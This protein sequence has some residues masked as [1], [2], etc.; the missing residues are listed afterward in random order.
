MKLKDN[1]LLNTNITVQA[2]AYLWSEIPTIHQYKFSLKGLSV[3][4]MF[5]T[6]RFWNCYVIQTWN[7]VQPMLWICHVI[8]LTSFYTVLK[9][10][11]YS[12][13]WE[14][15]NL[16]AEFT[17]C[18]NFRNVSL[19][20]AQGWVHIL[21]LLEKFCTFSDQLRSP[22]DKPNLWWWEPLFSS[23]SIKSRSVLFSMI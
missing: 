3:A 11:V 8:S 15:M 23:E 20:N 19:I 7:H 4:A 9:Y 22:K 6:L 1:K 18:H 16:T 12:I 5:Y 14:S 10:L 13:I 2:Q 21:G 17:V